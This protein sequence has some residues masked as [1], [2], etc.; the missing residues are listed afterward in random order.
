MD[1]RGRCYT[2]KIVYEPL[3]VIA[4]ISAWNYPYLVGVNVFIP[5][6][7]G[8]NAVLYKPRIC[9][10]HRTAYTKIVVPV[11]HTENVFQVIIGRG[12]AGRALLELP[13]N[14]YFFTG[15][16]RTGKYIAEQTASNWYQ[17]N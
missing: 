10:A 17:F 1:N 5:A 14:G 16:Y 12:T 2:R 3:G 15:S 6:I 4:N 11:G 8:G 7:I 9:H 13:L